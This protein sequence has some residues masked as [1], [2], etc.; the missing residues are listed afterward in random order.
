MTLRDRAI[1]AG[2]RFLRRCYN[3]PSVRFAFAAGWLA[4]WKA[5]RRAK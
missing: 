2:E 4:G 1:A 5:A 3:V